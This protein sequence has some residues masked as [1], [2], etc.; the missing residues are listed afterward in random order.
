[1]GQIPVEQTIAIIEATKEPTN[2][3]WLLLIAII[4]AS[5]AGI[6]AYLTRNYGKDIK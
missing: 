6:T 4:P 3:W 1:M 2:H 5:I